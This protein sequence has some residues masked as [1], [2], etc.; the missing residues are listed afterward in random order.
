LII[1]HNLFLGFPFIREILRQSVFSS[2]ILRLILAVSLAYNWVSS[3]MSC[4]MELNK[5]V[6]L[7]AEK[8]I[9]WGNC[10]I[11][12][13]LYI[14][15]PVLPKRLLQTFSYADGP[16]FDQEGI[17]WYLSKAKHLQSQK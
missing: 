6:I 9:T 15:R 4:K 2:S 12:T 11:R 16:G 8:G 7:E 17:E 10:A 1:R 13:Y 5:I 14:Q 3:E